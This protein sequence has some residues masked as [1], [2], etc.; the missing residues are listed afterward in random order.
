MCV[1]CVAKGDTEVTWEHWCAECL[2]AK[3]WAHKR[4]PR[5]RILL[6]EFCRVLCGKFTVQVNRD[7]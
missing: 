1:Q 2:T 5:W 7:R 4:D 6:R 3:P